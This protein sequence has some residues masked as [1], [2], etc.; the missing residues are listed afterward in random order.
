MLLTFAAVLEC[1]THNQMH[2]GSLEAKSIEAQEKKRSKYLCT[3]ETVEKSY[4]L[5]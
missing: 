5:Y 4:I 3:F 2:F 1:Q